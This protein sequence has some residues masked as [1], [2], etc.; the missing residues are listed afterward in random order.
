MRRM[1]AHCRFPNRAPGNTGAASLFSG[2]LQPQVQTLAAPCSPFPVAPLLLAS[3]PIATAAVAGSPQTPLLLHRPAPCRLPSCEG[4]TTTAQDA[5]TAAS[6]AHRNAP[7]QLP[8][9]PHRVAVAEPPSRLSTHAAHVEQ[10]LSRRA[11]RSS[12]SPLLAGLQLVILPV[13][14]ER[15]FLSLELRVL[16]DLKDV[17]QDP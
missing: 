3:S 14:T 6:P 2:R 9:S 5:A 1:R 8:H 11:N 13:A 4:P 15:P 10:C 12:A 17:A 7:L 16:E